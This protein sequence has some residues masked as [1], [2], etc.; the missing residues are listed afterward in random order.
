MRINKPVCFLTKTSQQLPGDNMKISE[1]TAMRKTG[2]N[3]ITHT[4]ENKF[5]KLWRWWVSIYYLQHVAQLLLFCLKALCGQYFHWQSW[6]SKTA[7]PPAPPLFPPPTHTLLPNQRSRSDT[8]SPCNK[9]LPVKSIK[10]SAA[11]WPSHLGLLDT[12]GDNHHHIFCLWPK[13]REARLSAFFTPSS[14]IAR[15]AHLCNVDTFA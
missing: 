12:A 11:L 13:R 6:T 3:H 9:K 7:R 14:F 2:L 1:Q 4:L 5:V 8:Y 10:R 15:P